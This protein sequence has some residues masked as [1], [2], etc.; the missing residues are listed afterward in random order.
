MAYGLLWLLRPYIWRYWTATWQYGLQ[1]LNLPAIIKIDMF[2]NAV[3]QVPLLTADMDAAGPSRM[4]LLVTF[5]ISGAAFAASFIRQGKWLPIAYLARGLGVFQMFVCLY[6]WVW[7]D[8]FV[9][10]AMTHLRYVFLIQLSV[11]Y[12]LPVILTLIFYPLDL[13]LLKKAGA[14]ALMLVYLCIAVPWLMLLHAIVLQHGT[15]LFMPF[16]YFILGGPFLI[17]LN[18]AL[19]SYCASWEGTLTES[20]RSR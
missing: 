8:H 10:S 2:S 6:F 19:Y 14:T 15:L 4:L 13:S 18:V 3:M 1:Q 17:M 5:L 20:R 7:P 16:A 12:I 9:Y 11:I